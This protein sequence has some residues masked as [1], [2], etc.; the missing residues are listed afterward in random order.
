MQG[1]QTGLS[2]AKRRAVAEEVRE[3]QTVAA[4]TYCYDEIILD[5]NVLPS[6]GPA[7]RRF[8][9]GRIAAGPPCLDPPQN[10]LLD[11]GNGECPQRPD[12]DRPHVVR[13]DPTPKGQPAVV[14][15]DGRNRFTKPLSLNGILVVQ[16]TAIICSGPQPLRG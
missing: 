9:A 3:R 13:P 8:I 7:T 12:R 2:T 16:R 6:H 4:R 1:R 11:H 14:H 15:L 5:A 10:L